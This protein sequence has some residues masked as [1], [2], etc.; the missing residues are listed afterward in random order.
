MKLSPATALT[1]TLEARL[2]AA[3]ANL[4]DF[5][6]SSIGLTYDAVKSSLIYKAAKAEY[7]AAFKDLRDHNTQRARQS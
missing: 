1:K 3:A 5:P 2:Y 7:S 4:K 6:R